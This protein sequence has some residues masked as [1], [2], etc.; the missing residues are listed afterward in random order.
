MGPFRFEVN[1][2]ILAGMLLAIV[3][4]SHH[5]TLVESRVLPESPSSSQLADQG[6]SKVLATLGVVCRCCN[7]DGECTGPLDTGSCHR[8]QC[9][10]WKL[11]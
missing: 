7:P 8:V 9:L 5:A 11:S 1:Y 6:I 10:P 2:L 4:A 3:S